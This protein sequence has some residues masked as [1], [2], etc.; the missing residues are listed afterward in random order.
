[1]QMQPIMINLEPNNSTNI[2]WHSLAVVL[3]FFKPISVKNFIKITRNCA[4]AKF[5]LEP[6]MLKNLK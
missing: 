2:F 5:N 1:M 3:Q 4:G 6:V